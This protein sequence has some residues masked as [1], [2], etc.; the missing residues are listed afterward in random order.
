M[1]ISFFSV[2]EDNFIVSLQERYKTLGE[3]EKNFGVLV[4]F[5]DLPK[6]EI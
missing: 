3:D 1:E 5:P 6:E 4:N 2:E